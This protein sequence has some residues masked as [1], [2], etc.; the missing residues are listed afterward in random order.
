MKLIQS[1]WF[2]AAVLALCL[3]IGTFSANVNAAEGA[4]LSIKIV[5]DK[6]SASL[7]DTVT[8]TYTITNTTSNN[9]TN[10]SLIDNKLGTITLPKT[11][12]ASSGNITVTNTHLVTVSDY[13]GPFVNTATVKG[14]L[15]TTNNATASSNNVTASTSASVNLNPYTGSIKVT[16][17]ADKSSASPGDVITYTFTVLNN[18]IV[19]LS[20]LSLS[21]NKLG[22]ISLAT[23]SLSPGNSTTISKTYTVLE[24]DLPGPLTNI[25]TVQGKDPAGQTVSGQSN[26]VSVSLTGG[27]E[28]VQTKAD[29]LKSRGVPGKGIENAP[30]LQK[31]FNPNSKAA[32]NA[33]KKD[34]DKKDK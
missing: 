4:E 21:D 24:T 30:G 3:A 1:L 27:S 23:A 7:G 31:P 25:A 22:A 29:I 33:G 10:L 12:L 20:N 17:T 11:T 15:A 14:V 16:K 8:Y 5:P 9:I 2:K 13:P 18:G 34:K 26:Q 28:D 6:D 32:E 19:E